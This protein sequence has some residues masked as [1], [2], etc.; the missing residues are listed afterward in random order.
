[1]SNTRA[2]ALVRDVP[3]TELR[4]HLRGA[5]ETLFVVAGALDCVSI[6][7]TELEAMALT[8]RDDAKESREAQED[9][10]QRLE[11]RLQADDEDR[12]LAR[13]AELEEENDA[14]RSERDAAKRR[15]AEVEPLIVSYSDLLATAR[16]FVSR[17][18]AAGVPV[19]HVR[20]ASR[21]SAAHG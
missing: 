19:K 21:K 11:A 15:L 4:T 20:R 14:L 18:N 1:M 2:W 13:I 5:Y 16:G 7:E 6:D 3:D 12:K 9:A 17:A 8:L 10:E